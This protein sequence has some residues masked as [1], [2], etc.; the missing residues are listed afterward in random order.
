MGLGNDVGADEA[1]APLLE[2]AKTAD[3]NTVT[4]GDTIV[5]SIRIGSIGLLAADDVRVTDT[6]PALQEVVTAQASQGAV[7][8]ESGFGGRVFV[9]AGTIPP[10][11]DLQVTVTA[12]VANSS[13]PVVV[14]LPTAMRNNVLAHTD[15]AGD[16]SAYVDVVLHDCACKVNDLPAIY[17]NVQDAIDAAGAPTDV[18]KVAGGCGGVNTRGGGR[19]VAYIDKTLTLRGGYSTSDWSHS[20]PV[21]HPSTLS[22]EGFGRTIH[23]RGGVSPLIENLTIKGGNS[24]GLSGSE[25]D[26][27]AGGGIY[28][29]ESNP[30]ITSCTIRNNTSPYEGGGVYLRKGAAM[31]E[32]NLITSNTANRGGGLFV[33][34]G[35]PVLLGNVFTVNRASGNDPSG[36]AVLLDEADSNLQNNTLSENEALGAASHAGGGGLA[37]DYGKLTAVGNRLTS[38]TVNTGSKYSIASGGGAQI[39]YSAV[40]FTDNEVLGNTNAVADQ[41]Y[42]AGVYAVASPS[43]SILR[44]VFVGN[45]FAPSTPT[46][47]QGSGG[48]A[49]FGNCSG[50]VFNANHL[51]SNT[52]G[53]IGALYVYSCPGARVANNMVIQNAAGQYGGMFLGNGSVNLWNNTIV[54]NGDTAVL[55]QYYGVVTAKNNI[56]AGHRYGVK[57]EGEGASAALDGTLWGTGEWG[58]TT[59]TQGNVTIGS[60]NLHGDPLFEDP[61]VQD[62]H[63]TAGSP[64]VNA[65]VTVALTGDIDGDL[66][67]W[68]A[69]VDIGADEY[70]EASVGADLSV[71]KQGPATAVKD[72][73]LSY[74][75]TVS[76]AGPMGAS[77]A[78]VV[79]TLPAAMEFVAATVSQGAWSVTSQTVV[80][81]LGLLPNGAGADITIWAIVRGSGTLTNTA[82]VT[83]VQTDPVPANNS[84]SV[85]TDVP[86]QVETWTD[87]EFTTGG[88]R[89]AR[90]APTAGARSGSGQRAGMARLRPGDRRLLRRGDHGGC[91]VLPHHGRDRQ[92]GPVDAL[93]GRSGPGNYVRAKYYIFTAGQTNPAQGNSDPVHAAAP[94]AAASRSTRCWRCSTT[95]TA[96]RR[97]SRWRQDLR[98][99]ADPAHAVAVPRGLRSRGCAVSGGE[100]RRRRACCGRSR[101]SAPT[102]R[103]TA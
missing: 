7:S 34:Q 65:G 84:S 30:L 17:D 80:C 35:K 11:E 3:R 4:F 66:R 37:T 51:T 74:T 31:L 93:L 21:A 20:D 50:L 26:K 83:A 88:T 5:Y 47:T 52:A 86:W 92:P 19:Q 9:S 6:L 99:S 95:S 22:A 12:Q 100:R 64:A 70:I 82:V 41:G 72:E 67:P 60:V 57:V 14:E 32:G 2:A 59:E 61:A 73:V 1:P 63:I 103:T 75:I 85:Q 77:D 45:T 28:S 46:S 15:G 24:A 76:N 96:T 71:V 48:G 55:V 54:G 39:M 8:W 10:G 25:W 56:V 78:T 44:N 94:L 23:I 102:R 18:V 42:G 43:A 101:R 49:F 16:A 68:G 79:D 53:S 69:G 36:G 87:D 33:W 29:Y 27:D 81:N 40:V 58:N 62:F 13:L 38:N 98:P 91:A 90:L 89:A 97:S